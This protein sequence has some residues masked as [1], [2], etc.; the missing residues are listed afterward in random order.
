MSNSIVP[1]QDEN[2]P[3]IEEQPV[4]EA[5][6]LVLG[7]LSGQLVE[8]LM[9]KTGGFEPADLS[10]RMHVNVFSPGKL[11]GNDDINPENIQAGED[12]PF[13]PLNLALNYVR[14]MEEDMKAMHKNHV[15][16]LDKIDKCYYDIEQDTHKKYRE[17][18]E[19]YK[20]QHEFKYSKLRASYDENKKEKEELKN[21]AD[22]TIKQLQAKIRELTEEKKKLL[23]DYNQSLEGGQSSSQAAIKAVE[24]E[25]LM[26]M[27]TMKQEH[28]KNIEQLKAVAVPIPVPVSASNNDEIN[29]LNREIV[30][31]KRQLALVVVPVVDNKESEK[32]ARENFELRQMLAEMEAQQRNDKSEIE[33]LKS[34]VAR[35][36]E[37]NSQLALLIKSPGVDEGLSLE[38]RESFKKQL[39]E[40]QALYTSSIAAIS[41]ERD[42]LKRELDAIKGHMNQPSDSDEPEIQFLKAQLTF[43]NT[44]LDNNRSTIAELEANQ[45]KIQSEAD[46]SQKRQAELSAALT[47]SNDRVSQLEAQ[48]ADILSKPPKVVSDPED[49]KKIAD[50]EVLIAKLNVKPQSD[51]K[52]KERIAEL[53]GKLREL[54]KLGV[55]AAPAVSNLEAQE[56]LDRKALEL[57]RANEEIASLKEQLLQATEIPAAMMTAKSGDDKEKASLRKQ[58][59]KAHNHITLLQE[60]IE[61]LKQ[62]RKDDKELELLNTQLKQAHA[63]IVELESKLRAL[64][65][66]GKSSSS[67]AI[68]AVL[69]VVL[70]S[71]SS[72]EASG[73]SNEEVSALKEELEFLKLENERLS[74]E[75]AAMVGLAADAQ[76]SGD[77]KSNQ[78]IAQ[79]EAEL[80]SRPDQKEVDHLKAH[81]KLLE[82]QIQESS[83]SS[84]DQ[85]KK[86]QQQILALQNTHNEKVREMEIQAKNAYNEN[87]GIIKKMAHD[88]ANLQQD[89]TELEAALAAAG[90]SQAKMSRE[91]DELRKVAGQA[92]EY[93]KQV[94]ALTATVKEM[95]EH[96]KIKEN[97]LKESIRQRKLL[98]NQLEDLK[99]K[100]R[101]FCRVRPLSRREL[102]MDSV[103]I[104]SIVDEFT[105]NCEAKT[106]QIK[107][108]MYDSVFGPNSTQDDV[109]ED[110]KRLVQSAVDGYNVCIFAYGQ[111]GSGKTFTIQGSPDNPGVTPR[112]VDELFRILNSMPSHYS[113]EVKC[114]MVELYLDNLVDLFC[115]KENLG[116]PPPLNIKKDPKGMVVI[117]EAFQYTIK[118][119]K[120][121]MDKFYE[122]NQNRHTSS[123]KMNDTSSRSHL[124]FSVLIDVMNHETQQRT[125]G[126]LSL[127]DLAGSERV[128]KT[129]ATAERLKEGRAINKSLAALGD[130]ISALSSGE[131]HI[132]YRN[133]KLTMLMSDSLGGTAKTLM[134]VNVSPASYNREETMMSLYYAARVKLIQNEPI[135]NI[136]SKEMSNMK[137]MI[138]ELTVERDKLKAALEASGIDGSQVDRLAAQVRQAEEFNDAKYDE[139]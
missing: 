34:E 4:Q 109:F 36:T 1:S 57:E 96:N 95:Q 126:K 69:P 7:A 32:L 2:G 37:D 120:E 107:P 128:S 74:N 49:K 71:S 56:E 92:E 100:I 131:Q 6:A 63:R 103:N 50:L 29:R 13:I 111:T 129:E 137:Q 93:S 115:P 47:L 45:A 51:G 44:E 60:E 43:L 5:P 30:E 108:F 68:P 28:E 86:L 136:E 66:A 26:K 125:V 112:A 8:D 116:N 97:E 24:H 76:A 80:S 89:K 117:P 54:S 52:D 105:I 20:S 48:L 113:W 91:I 25:Y 67:Q 59:N 127:V 98:H 78:R 22:E 135:K 19:K 104:T 35:L 110:T 11:L 21:W 114:Y 70:P 64:K 73:A 16:I 132:P 124:I 9:P 75:K 55:V 82:S 102:E 99:G 53:E 121:L 72:Q 118:T 3:E 84:S 14:K 138:I 17:F 87:Q 119:P 12:I 40:Q 46:S 31:L 33:R 10:D 23:E 27:E 133:N 62:E 65:D 81:I 61:K 58:L 123:T 18:I 106:G 15:S 101:V 41:S 38:E 130:V 83:S 122:G 79:L 94:I 77:S 134:F 88:Q 90:A 139:L 42:S 85:L 39:D